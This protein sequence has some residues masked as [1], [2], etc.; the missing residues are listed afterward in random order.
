MK[1]ETTCLTFL[2]KLELDHHHFDADVLRI[3][4]AFHRALDQDRDS[5]ERRLVGEAL[6]S[7]RDQLKRHFEQEESEGCLWE[8]A[9]YNT[10]LCS[11]VTR[12]LGEHPLLLGRIDA[13]IA[14]VANSELAAD[15][16]TPALQEF[17]K[18]ARILAKH[19]KREA[20]ILERSLPNA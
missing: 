12:I 10:A 15:W 4:S 2:K 19:E 17:D 18:L 7:L 11:D 3:R 8:A 16:V 13:V 1:N 14:A 20:A 9:S 5:A 6:R